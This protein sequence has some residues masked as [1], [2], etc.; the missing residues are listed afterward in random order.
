MVITNTTDNSSGNKTSNSSSE[1][2]NSDRKI[3]TAQEKDKFIVDSLRKLAE[4]R[5]GNE[6]SVKKLKNE[7]S[8]A[9]PNVVTRYKPDNLVDLDKL[10]KIADVV[11]NKTQVVPDVAVNYTLSRDGVPVMTKPLTR[12]EERNDK[13]ISTTEENQTRQARK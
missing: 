4:V 11:V 13:S 6:G 5:T 1:T 12:I 8:I 2:S 3:A 10:K 9:T 7:S